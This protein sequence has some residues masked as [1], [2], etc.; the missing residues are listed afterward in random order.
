[1]STSGARSFPVATCSAASFFYSGLSINFLFGC[2]NHESHNQNL[3]GGLFAEV[4]DKYAS[5]SASSSTASAAAGGLDTELGLKLY[6]TL[7]V[8][9]D[10]MPL[11]HLLSSATSGAMA[12]S[13][14]ATPTVATGSGATVSTPTA[15]T[16]TSSSSTASS[17][18]A[19]SPIASARSIG[20]SRGS[21]NNGSN[22]T[23][24][25]ASTPGR[26]IFV[27][28]G[29]LMSHPGVT[30]QAIAS[31]NRKR[32]IPYGSPLFEDHIFESLEWSDPRTALGTTPSDRGAGSFFGPDVTTAF[33][34]Q[35]GISLIVRSHECVQEGYSLMHD[36]RIL[37][38]FSASR[39]CGRGNNR[40][41]FV[42]FF[43]NLRHRVVQYTACPLTTDHLKPSLEPM[44][45]LKR[46]S[47]G[48]TSG[49]GLM[50]SPLSSP[51]PWASM[52][53]LGSPTPLPAIDSAEAAAIEESSALA[54]KLY[55]CV[56][57]IPDAL[58]SERGSVPGLI[59]VI[60]GLDHS[61]MPMTKI[62]D[63]VAPGY[64]P[65]PSSAHTAASEGVRKML[66]ERVV[67]NRAELY[68][69]WAKL[70]SQAVHHDGC[71][72]KL[73]WADGMHK[74]LKI[75]LPWVSLAPILCEFEEGSNN[76]R[77][78][79]SKFLDRY[80]IAAVG[81]TSANWI[82]ALIAQI[83]QKLFK[84]CGSLEAAFSYIDAD[85]SG[86]ISL[87]EMENTLSKLNLGIT[88]AQIV[89]LINA[90]D[91]DR[92]GSIS[93]PEFESRFRLLFS[94]LHDDEAAG[95]RKKQPQPAQP[96]SGT[97][98]RHTSVASSSSTMSTGSLSGRS[99]PSSSLDP[100]GREALRKVAGALFGTPI[101]DD[102]SFA[103]S[104][105]DAALKNSFKL[106]DLNRDGLISQEE[107][108]IGVQ[109][110]G[111]GYNEDDVTR[112][113][114]AIDSNAS[115]WINYQ[116]WTEAFVAAGVVSASAIPSAASLAAAASTTPSPATTTTTTTAPSSPSTTSTTARPR[117]N[118]GATPTTPTSPL[119]IGSRGSSGHHS[120]NSKSSP[121][122]PLP[123]NAASAW[124]NR[125]GAID[126]ILA[127]L[128]EFRTELGAAFKVFDTDGNGEISR[129]EFREGLRALQA[130]STTS[131]STGSSS[132][133]LIS[134]EMAD[135]IMDS[136]DTDKSGSISF[137]EFLNGFQ[138]YDNEAA[139]AVGSD[140]GVV[141]S[142][143]PSA[144]AGA[145]ALA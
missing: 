136:L 87:V 47:A 81:E 97:S 48:A 22:A 65:P 36:N 44:A 50:T 86:E 95:Q 82:D 96:R 116:E 21:L 7:Q 11:V 88:K 62:E 77:I 124:H 108:L 60:P 104:P 67:L 80:R 127:I 85:G 102:G 79:Y 111:I 133:L 27:T 57:A 109:K 39:Y 69:Y 131:P 84:V 126:S 13:S 42:T 61:R 3:T 73:E 135:A 2:S 16:A 119:S 34:R 54:A 41:S 53:P 90:L 143:P 128:Y 12:A 64:V 91:R 89:D 33:C 31:I 28:H 139:A 71:V 100:W 70:P 55:D 17:G 8:A 125:T 9:F 51:N 115:G 35:N 120:N 121:P 103:P 122:S 5:Y 101:E 118:S 110:L 106:L 37:T 142:L 134:D 72:S 68:A 6:D 43:P 25:G 83:C 76:T 132:S 105:D 130:L 140:R 59:H 93:W 107:L 4:L 46:A 114:A 49:S 66:M 45:F 141:L 40:G 56:V 75:N 74:V 144:G 113:L 24:G 92:S 58:L 10:N 129:E 63:G 18:S 15:T 98:S 19:S 1:V 145:F 138:L 14:T 117:T 23:S 20:T 26:R 112:L 32:D 78:N 137:N 99:T 52:S 38:V 123:A 30:L 29:G 94:K